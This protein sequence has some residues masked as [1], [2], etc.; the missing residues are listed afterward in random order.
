M[1]LFAIVFTFPFVGV[2][3]GIAFGIDYFS[4][5]RGR[6]VQLRTIHAGDESDTDSDTDPDK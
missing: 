3:I 1:I 6:V 4:L 5:H 2:G